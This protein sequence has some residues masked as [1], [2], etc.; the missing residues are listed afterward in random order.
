MITMQPTIAVIACLGGFASGLVGVGGAVILI[1]LLLYVPPFVTGTDL[2]IHAV[3][4]LT[5]IT[6][7]AGS[8]MSAAGHARRGYLSGDIVRRVGLPMVLAA[9]AGGA[10]SSVLPPKTL[11]FV[12][13]AMAT[14]AFVLITASPKTTGA[15]VNDDPRSLHKSVGLGGGVGFSAGLVGAGGT[16]LLLPLMERVLAVPFRQ[17][18]ASSVAIAFLTACASGL[19]KLV[20]AQVP[21]P[22]IVPAVLG[23]L[24]GAALGVRASHALPIRGLRSILGAVTLIVALGSWADF[25]GIAGG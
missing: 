21:L 23:T 7:G 14:M 17:A 18:V 19:G 2:G 5:A 15:A 1:P 20:T 11:L 9:A 8:L 13:A 10:A 3:T 6:V 16:F 12:F 22:L 24:A 4:A 25:F